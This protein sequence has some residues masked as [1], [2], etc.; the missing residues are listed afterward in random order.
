VVFLD[1]KSDFMKGNAF[2]L[3]VLDIIF[4]AGASAMPSGSLFI[5]CLNLIITVI[6]LYLARYWWKTVPSNTR[7]NSLVSFV[8]FA[9]V[10]FFAVTPLLRISYGS[11]LF[12]TFFIL[13]LLVLGYSLYKKEIIFQAFHRPENSKVAKGVSLFLL[14]LIVISAFS[15]RNGQELI[16]LR[17]LS[18]YQGV[19]FIFFILYGIGILFTF[20][21]TAMLKKPE[22]IKR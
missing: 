16:I 15:F 12:W 4:G 17:L 13:Y 21:A 1:K 22:E 14:V 2:G 7:Y 10:G 9:S 18:D 20:I 6:G 5:F 8:S 3:L 11:L 19:F